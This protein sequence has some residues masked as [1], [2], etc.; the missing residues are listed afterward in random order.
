[1]LNYSW[2]DVGKA[3]MWAMGKYPRVIVTQ[4]HGTGIHT[5]PDDLPSYSLSMWRKTGLEDEYH[6]L[7][8]TFDQR[9]PNREKN[10]IAQTLTNPKPVI[11]M[12]FDAWTSPFDESNHV[13]ACMREM[14]SDRF[15]LIDLDKVVAQRVYDL[16]GLFDMAVGLVTVDTM[17][18]HLAAASNVEYVAFVRDDGQSGSIPKGNCVLSIGYRQW[19]EQRF[20]FELQMKMWLAKASRKIKVTP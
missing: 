20:A 10:L 6:M 14:L 2:Y 4:L 7:P 1:M 11:L 9:N 12:K 3:Q 19:H 5:V 16:L 18:L 8:L 15:Q 17:C 13:K